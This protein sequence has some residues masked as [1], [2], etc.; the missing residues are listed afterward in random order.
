MGRDGGSGAA[1]VALRTDM[2]RNARQRPRRDGEMRVLVT[3]YWP[4]GHR[5]EEFTWMRSLSP[6][7]DLLRRYKAGQVEWPRFASLYAEQVAADDAAQA[8][9]ADLHDA[10]ASGDK[11]VVLYCYEA[12]GL[13]CHRH[14]LR[15]M[16]VAGRAAGWAAERALFGDVGVALGAFTHGGH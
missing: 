1:R 4:H 5:R 11:E 13:P 12:P 6:S 10:A 2:I 8:H 16:V 14:I 3:R 9:I 15:E 7:A